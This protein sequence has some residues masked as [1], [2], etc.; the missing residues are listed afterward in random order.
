MCQI[1]IRPLLAAGLTLLTLTGCDNRT[2]E[3]VRWDQIAQTLQKNSKV[4][5][6]EQAKSLRGNNNH[7]H[8]RVPW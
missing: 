5:R 4:Q 8:D 2:K 6:W 3:A 1:I 7:Y